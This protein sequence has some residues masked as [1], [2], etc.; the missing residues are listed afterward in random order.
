MNKQLRTVVFLLASLASTTCFSNEE[1][2][3][4]PSIGFDGVSAINS[5]THFSR[6]TIQKVFPNSKIVESDV[7]TYS[8]SRRGFLVYSNESEDLI[9]KVYPTLKEDYIFAIFTNSSLVEGPRESRIGVTK[10]KELK[11]MPEWVEC[12]WGLNNLKNTYLCYGSGVR[13]L[14]E[15]PAGYK[16]DFSSAPQD[17]VDNGVLSEIMYWPGRPK[18]K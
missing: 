6:T 5:P 3:K 7:F 16:N 15:A 13:V 12:G 17:V 18:V 8:E 1:A 14:F 4:W 2:T 11:D 10:L 9:Y